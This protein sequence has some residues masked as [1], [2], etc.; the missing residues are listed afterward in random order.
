MGRVETRAIQ[1]PELGIIEGYFGPAWSWPE[2]LD[3][4]KRLRP[5]GYRMHLYAP[6][7]DAY[8]RRKWLEPHPDSELDQLSAFAG[9]C[10]ELGVR[11]GVGLSPFNAQ[12]DF[13][14]DVRQAM[15]DKIRLLN[16]VGLDDL[17]LLFDDMRGDI[18]DLA[19]RQ[20]D[21]VQFAVDRT[22]ATRIF[23]CPSFYTD[24]PVLDRMFGP[25]PDHY[26]EDLGRRLDESIAI[27]WTGEEVC[28]KEFSVGH[29]DRVANQMGRKPWLW[30]NYPV[31]DG[32]VMSRRLHLRG[33]T[34]R[35][36]RIAPHIQGHAI[37]PALQPVLGCIPALTLPESY[38]RGDQYQ[39]GEAFMSAAIAVCGEPLAQ[40]LSARL[41]A[42]NDVGI[43]QLADRRESL[44]RQFEAFDHPA[45]HEVVGWLNGRY[46]MSSEQVLTQ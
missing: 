11:F 26:L 34:G 37:N 18:A 25:R 30:D 14:S 17:A 28:S 13:G 38:S 3:V 43:D 21:I 9:S 15:A 6:K 12:L 20:A 36:A 10:R 39:Y 27:F 22:S 45:A 46:T 4:V 16:Q 32:A 40:T 42:L 23:V 8:L 33:F 29:L 2:R 24:D 5:A 1:V 31:N 35:P 7:A 44:L 19:Q 41:L